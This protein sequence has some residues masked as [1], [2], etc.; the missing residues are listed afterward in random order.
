MAQPTL[1][2][3]RR[4]KPVLSCTFCRGR[5]LRCDRQSPCGG[6]VRRGKAIECTY[7]SSEQERKDAVDYRPHTRGQQAR[8]RVA[9]LE[10]LVIEMRNMLQ[11]PSQP[12]DDTASRSTALSNSGPS[13]APPVDH[14]TD[15]MGRLRLT[16]HQAVYTGSSHWVTILDDIRHLKDE[17]SEEYSNSIADSEPPQLDDDLV[18]E[19][20]TNRVSLLNS[21]PSLSRE[22]ILAMVPPRKIVDR[23]VAQFF[24]NFDMAAFILHRNDF[25]A[26]YTNFWDNPSAV[27]IMWVGLLFAIMTTSA[28]LQQQ[29]VGALGFPAM[30]LQDLLTSYRTLTIHCLVAGDYLRPSRY[31][32]ETLLLHF[33]VDQNMNLDASIGNWV[34][35]G[36]IIRIALR[37][38]LHRDPSH[39][40]S[41]RPLQAELRRRLW[42]ALYQTDFFTSVQVGL[43]RIIKDSQCDT[44][45]PAHF[46]DYDIGPEH[47]EIPPERPLTEPTPLLCIIH[48]YKIIKVAT[49]IYDTTEAGPP[50]SDTVAS[51]GAKLERAMDAMPAW[52]KYRSLE[53]SVSHDPVIILHQI[54]IDVLVNKAIYLLHRRSFMKEAVGQESSK[55]SELCI[56]STLATLEHQRRMGEET[57][58]GGLMYG[59]RWR[60]DSSLTHE[61]LQATMILCFALSRFNNVRDNFTNS[62]SPPYRRDDILEA[63]S[64]AKG[65]WEKNA[66]RSVEARKA[67]NA[68]TAVLQ[69]GPYEPSASTLIASD[70]LF[71]QMPVAT[72]SQAYFNTFDYGQNTGLDP[73]LFTVDN[74]TTTFGSMLDDFSTEPSQM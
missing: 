73:S 40:S 43:P 60:V 66:D 16:E 35:I 22:Q 7:T 56:K 25:L 67:A 11:S 37:V 48:R 20:P 42:I 38:G 54:I 72:T 44:R 53:I 46:Y 64:L 17:L 33:V 10:N 71:G 27:P 13:L 23:H 50:S 14:V 69:Q 59:I 58:P 65:L 21:A 39:W 18:Y 34:L 29:D 62:H 5:K 32:I 68:I 52:L 31:T 74:D 49:E 19:S 41:I 70:A 3:R 12:S 6:C 1:H 57:Q 47:D 63:L 26:E 55:S 15:D 8:Q 4:D 30:E 9:H 2:S 61:F 28:F 24:N 45:P 36:V 51:L